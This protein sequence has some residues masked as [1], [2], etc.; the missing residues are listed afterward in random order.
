MTAINVAH[1]AARFKELND[2]RLTAPTGEAATALQILRATIA[3]S[4]FC[5]TH[6]DTILRALE[7]EEGG[8]AAY[9]RERAAKWLEYHPWNSDDD[10]DDI[11]AE[12]R[13]LPL[14]APQSAT[15]RISE[16]QLN[17]SD[18]DF[19]EDVDPQEGQDT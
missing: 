13:A 19:A 5:A 16:E 1:I 2:A 11:V 17:A 7:R 3:F 4:D 18:K 8:D 10:W 6:A 12:I 15:L 9:M 14:T